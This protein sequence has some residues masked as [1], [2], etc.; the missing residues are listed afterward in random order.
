MCVQFK[1]DCTI[2]CPEL[3]EE[4]NI[5]FFYILHLFNLIGG[6]S[7]TWC[8]II[9]SKWSWISEMLCSGAGEGPGQGAGQTASP[10]LN[11][12]VDGFECVNQNV[13]VRLTA[14]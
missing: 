1:R 4:F 7:D 13:D 5:L 9:L 14:S 6:D 2:L 10:L 12:S 3:G 8:V 11:L